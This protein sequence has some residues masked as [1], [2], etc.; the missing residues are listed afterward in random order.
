MEYGKKIR[1]GGFHLLKYKKDEMTFIKVSTIMGNWAMEYR[2][3]SVLFGFLDTDRT[4]E[5]DEALHVV[6]VNSFMA[7]TF[8]EADFQHEILDA[9]GRLQE[10]MNK[11]SEPISDEEDAGILESMKVEHEVIEE[12]ANQINGEESGE[13]DLSV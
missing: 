9:A 3:D 12:L 11:Q 10:R 13:A 7:A 6:I 1:L 5:Q 2:E 4:K 8:I